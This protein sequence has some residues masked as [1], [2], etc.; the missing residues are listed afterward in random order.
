MVPL[1]ARHLRESPRLLVATGVAAVV[2]VAVG[3]VIGLAVGGTSASAGPARVVVHTVA[4]PTSSAQ[5]AALRQRLASDTATIGGLRASL[6]HAQAQLKA[7]RA[8]SH[9][10]S[11]HFRTRHPGRR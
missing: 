9:T 2:L 6:K 7:A 11:K 10:H 4:Q 5:T 1:T 3:L 8:R